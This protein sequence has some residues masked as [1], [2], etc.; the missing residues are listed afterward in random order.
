ME[1]LESDRTRA[2]QA[3]RRMNKDFHLLYYGGIAAVL[4]ELRE[5]ILQGRPSN[6]L[7]LNTFT[8][9]EFSSAKRD[10][11]LLENAKAHLTILRVP[12]TTIRSAIRKIRRRTAN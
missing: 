11:E 9:G 6:L 1:S 2:W 10:V 3:Q 8:L 12:M 7:R 4:N 5:S